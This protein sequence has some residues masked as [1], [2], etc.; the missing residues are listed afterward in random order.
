[1][2]AGFPQTIK[3][4]NDTKKIK[5]TITVHAKTVHAKLVKSRRCF[6]EIPQTACYEN[7]IE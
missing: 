6:T 4:I 2:S 7:F 3:N 5:I 1:M